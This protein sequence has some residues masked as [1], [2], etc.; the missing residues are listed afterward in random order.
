M[1]RNDKYPKKK[2]KKN[3]PFTYLEM[4]QEIVRSRQIYQGSTSKY[5]LPI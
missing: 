2:T 5:M 3:N 1:W 4:I